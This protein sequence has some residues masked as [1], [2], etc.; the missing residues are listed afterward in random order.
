MGVF[1]SKTTIHVASTLYNLAGPEEDRPDF[2]KGTLFG[3]VMANSPSLSDDI[4]NA[5]FHGPGISQRSFFNYAVRNSLAGLPDITV[6]NSAPV[7][8]TVV[9]AQIPLPDSPPAPATLEISVQNATVVAGDPEPFLERWILE[10]HP[11]RIVELW[12]GDVDGQDF[13]VQFPNGDFFS[14]TDTDYSVHTRYI[15]AKYFLS[16]PSNDGVLVEGTPETVTVL[17]DFTGFTEQSSTPS[18]TPT[19][20]T[21]GMV[22]TRSFSDGTPDE[23][24][25]SVDVSLTGQELNTSETVNDRTVVISAVFYET[26]G[27]YQQYT[28]TGTDT[29]IGGYEDTVITDVTDIGGGVIR[30]TTQVTTGE[31]IAVSWDE[32]YDTQEIREGSL[33]GDERRFIYEVFTGNAVLDALATETDSSSF[34]EFF[35]F[36]PLRLDNVSLADDVYANIDNTLTEPDPARHN[37]APFGNGLY[38]ETRTAYRRATNESIDKLLDEIED[39]PD[40][41]DID[42]AYLMY[43]CA[44]NVQDQSC[45]KYIYNFFLEMRQFQAGDSTSLGT[46]TDSVD[47]YNDAIQ[48]LEDWQ[49]AVNAL[50]DET[51]YDSAPPKPT[52]PTISLP[53]ITTL[54]LKTTP[55]NPPVT[56]PFLLG[57]FPN[58]NPTPPVPPMIGFDIRLNWMFI[59]ETQHVGTYTFNPIIGDPRPAKKDEIE[60]VDGVTYTWTEK[61]GIESIIASLFTEINHSLPSIELYWQVDDNNYRKITIYGLVHQNFVYGGKAVSISSKEALEDTDVSGFII[62]LHAPTMKAMS[63]VDSTQMATANVHILFN[64]YQITKQKWYER[65]IFKIFLIVLFLVLAVIIAPASFAAG[66]G[67]LGGNVAIGSALGL[68]GTA[69]IVAGVVVNYLASLVISQLLSIVGTAIFGEKFGALFAAIVSFAFTAGLSGM[70]LFSAQGILGMAGVVANGY[71]GYVQGDLAEMQTEFEEE[72]S[73]YDEQMKYINDLIAGLGGNDLNFNPLSLTSSVYGNGRS[74]SGGYMPETADEFIRR[75]TMTGSDVVD[76]THAMV[77]DFVEVQQTLP[78]N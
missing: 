14:F 58:P 26:E 44:L 35:P 74:G 12:T 25:A 59:E 54:N 4:S 49:D 60:F 70:S 8:A 46:F 11:D 65:G 38:N 16:M 39:N 41:A 37:T 45:R 3:S 31:Q 7:D 34:Q 27:E 15:T 5:Y 19:G 68:S 9:A 2:L 6:S 47:D 13:S 66:G 22:E 21:R 73:Q 36:M 24:D 76:I 50:P 67:L 78:R 17:P 29:V 56:T 51:A 33:Y 43:G 72:T 57:L 53:P 10:N 61:Q 1:S 62:P 28:H 55:L 64:S 30:T 32:Q 75:T 18:F 23:V 40:I 71:A 69:A 48:A 52:I 63:L 42:Y 20:L 77:N